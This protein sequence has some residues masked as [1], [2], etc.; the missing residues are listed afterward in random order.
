MKSAEFFIL[1][2]WRELAPAQGVWLQAMKRSHQLTSLSAGL[3]T[4]EPAKHLEKHD[5]LLDL[6]LS[7]VLGRTAPLR[8]PLQSHEMLNHVRRD[9]QRPQPIGKQVGVGIALPQAEVIEFHGFVADLP[10]T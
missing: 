1:R 4:S 7:L 9:M 10:N 2:H 8:P 5:P 3:T 6:P